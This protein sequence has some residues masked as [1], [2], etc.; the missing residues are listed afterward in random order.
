MGEDAEGKVF[1]RAPERINKISRGGA[2]IRFPTPMRS[3]RSCFLQVTSAHEQWGR[4]CIHWGSLHNG[5]LE[6]NSTMWP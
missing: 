6:K 5:L 4:H 1:S 3:R 2:N